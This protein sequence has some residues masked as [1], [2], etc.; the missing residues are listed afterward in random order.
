MRATF[1]FGQKMLCRLVW[2]LSVLLFGVACY[3]QQPVSEAVVSARLEA[4][5]KLNSLTSAGT[6]PWHLRLAVQLYADDGKP[7]DQGTIEEWWFDAK[8]SRVVYTMPG[9]NTILLQNDAGRFHSAG[10][11]RPGY[12]TNALLEQVVAPIVFLA[13][14]N[15]QAVLQARKI[16]PAILDC[17]SIAFNQKQMESAV[18]TQMP[19][20]CLDPKTDA[21]LMD[22]E[23]SVETIARKQ[24]SRFSNH[25]VAL[26]LT[27]YVAAKPVAS[28]HVDSLQG[29]PA[30]SREVLEPG[31]LVP[32]DAPQVHLTGAIT[33]GLI[34]TQTP[35]VYPAAR[36]TRHISGEVVLSG[37]ITREG[38]MSQLEV[39]NSPDAALSASAMEAVKQWRYKPYLVDGKPVSVETTVTCVF[40]L[41]N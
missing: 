37:V 26:D 20:Y 28:A 12:F 23:F 32:D 31:E 11:G 21:L 9:F 38:K 10:S 34:L 15:Q 29:W 13:G 3:G 4:A 35:M 22:T 36:K 27:I 39:V 8:H 1:S 18:I 7:A 40:A 5:S 25:Q 41:A 30:A 17:L 2:S 6:V 14:A 19:T 24:I 33:S 16:G